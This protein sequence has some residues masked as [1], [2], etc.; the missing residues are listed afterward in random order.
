MLPKSPSGRVIAV[1]A[2]LFLAAFAF[3]A[4]VAQAAEPVKFPVTIPRST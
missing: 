2:A 4:G 3:A 1:I